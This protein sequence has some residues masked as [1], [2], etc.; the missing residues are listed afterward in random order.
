MVS[1]V[2]RKEAGFFT[3]YISHFRHRENNSGNPYEYGDSTLMPHF[4]VAPGGSE[5]IRRLNAE[6]FLNLGIVQHSVVHPDKVDRAIEAR[7]GFPKTM[8]ENSVK[9][10]IQLTVESMFN[11]RLQR[12]SLHAIYPGIKPAGVAVGIL[13]LVGK[14]NVVPLVEP[15]IDEVFVNFLILYILLPGPF[16]V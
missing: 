1:C 10:H 4:D 6:V 7:I 15:D 2:K 9:G 5:F 11:L 8:G 12:V 13:F 14:Q 3:V 16:E